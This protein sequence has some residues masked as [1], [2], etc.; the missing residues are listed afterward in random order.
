MARKKNAKTGNFS[1][2]TNFW[3]MLR[4]IFVASLNKG[5]FPIAI[6]GAV[7]IILLVKM[8]LE[9]STKLVFELLKL[10]KSLHLLGWGLFLLTTI[11]WYFNSKKLRRIHSLEMSRVSVEKKELQETLIGRSLQTSN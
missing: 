1:S 8:P 10:F 6:V 11:G 3:G 9:A 5:Q 2:N 4:D 7:M